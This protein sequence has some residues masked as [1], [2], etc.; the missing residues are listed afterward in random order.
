MLFQES[1]EVILVDD[2]HGGFVY[3]ESSFKPMEGA[4]EVKSL[5]QACTMVA[6][7]FWKINDNLK[8]VKPT[9]HPNMNKE[10]KTF[11]CYLW[12]YT[13]HPKYGSNMKQCTEYYSKGE[14][15]K[16]WT[17]VEPNFGE[18]ISGEPKSDKAKALQEF[19]THFRGGI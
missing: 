14:P 12:E 17:Q 2:G 1:I 16:E 10:A 15:I 4:H 9:K 5:D 11:K 13:G 3:P 6:D 7:G 19:V 8:K 18:P